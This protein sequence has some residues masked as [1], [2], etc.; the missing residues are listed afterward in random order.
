[1]RDSGSDHA[2]MIFF[3]PSQC[4]RLYLVCQLF[5]FVV[6]Q[7][8]SIFSQQIEGDTTAVVVVPAIAMAE[9]ST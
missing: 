7:D 8:R 4:F 6:A 2:Y 1:M 3:A 5:I 9:I